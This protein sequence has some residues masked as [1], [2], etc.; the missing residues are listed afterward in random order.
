MNIHSTLLFSLLTAAAAKDLVFLAGPHHSESVE[1]GKLFFHH[2]TGEPSQNGLDGWVWPQVDED[3]PGDDSRAF[4]NF[5]W[6]PDNSTMKEVLMSSIEDAW[7]TA[8]HGIIVGAEGFDNTRGNP[9]SQGLEIMTEIVER[10]NVRANNVH[11]VVMYRSPRIEQWIS[12]FQSHDMA[13]DEFVCDLEYTKHIANI[14]MNPLMLAGAYR[15]QD[16]NVAVV[17]T[18]GTRSKNLDVAHTV[19]CDVLSNVNCNGG[20]VTGLKNERFLSETSEAISSIEEVQAASEMLFTKRDCY[21]EEALVRDDRVRLVHPVSMWTDC[22][23]DAE[24][25]QEY[26]ELAS[27][28]HFYQELKDI[29]GC[30]SAK[31]PKWKFAEQESAK[32]ISF[33]LIASFIIACIVIAFQ[34]VGKYFRSQS[35]YVRS[36]TGKPDASMWVDFADEAFQVG[37]LKTNSDDDD[38]AFTDVDLMSPQAAQAGGKPKNAKILAVAKE[39]RSVRDTYRVGMYQSSP[40]T[41]SKPQKG[42]SQYE[43]NIKKLEQELV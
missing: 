33:L 27:H 12:L 2:A 21:Y 16:W 41:K 28:D 17:D 38:D 8:K 3:L 23:S 13:Y 7:G 26:S 32:L 15:T 36:P 24:A 10:L 43:C 29:N 34:Q 25:K 5:F 37:N 42:D 9:D 22:D 1:V 40:A 39:G 19:A 4:E 18:G 30:D 20:F 11:V 35:N 6:N 14:P 31:G